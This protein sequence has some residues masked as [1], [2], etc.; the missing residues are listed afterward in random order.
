RLNASSP[1]STQLPAAA[2]A[3]RASWDGP[4]PSW[5]R[6]RTEVSSQSSLQLPATAGAGTADNALSSTLASNGSSTLDSGVDLGHC[7]RCGTPYTKSATKGWCL[8]CGYLP[9]KEEAPAPEPETTEGFSKW[10]WPLLA[11]MAVILILSVVG[12]L[13][14]PR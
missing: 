13:M 10:G 4:R 7:P 3:P 12:S 6:P 5:E 9:E 14:L 11:G 2:P 1:S 8:S